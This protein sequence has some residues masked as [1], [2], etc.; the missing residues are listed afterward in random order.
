MDMYIILCI[1]YKILILFPAESSTDK[2]RSDGSPSSLQEESQ[3][4]T[5]ERLKNSV[6][7]FLSKQDVVPKV[8]IF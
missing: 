2:L 4:S 8:A 7:E 6:Q 3:D 1:H 5:L